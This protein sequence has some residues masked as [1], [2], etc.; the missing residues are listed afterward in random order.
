MLLYNKRNNKQTEEAPYRMK[1]FVNQIS[2]KGLRVN[3]WSV[4][5]LFR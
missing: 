5:K 2:Y 1:V 4:Q 3:M